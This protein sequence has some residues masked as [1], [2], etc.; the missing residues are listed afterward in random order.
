[1]GKSKS[2]RRDRRVRVRGEERTPPDVRKL[3]KALIALAF[4]QAQAETDARAAKEGPAEGGAR[5]PESSR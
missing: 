5:P 2:N 4:A 1:M 3:S